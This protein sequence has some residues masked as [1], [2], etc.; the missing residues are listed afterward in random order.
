MAESLTP[1]IVSKHVFNWMQET[2]NSS[3]TSFKDYLK[4]DNMDEAKFELMLI[5]Y[6]TLVRVLKRD[7]ERNFDEYE[8]TLF[9]H[10]LSYA[11]SKGIIAKLSPN[12]F[13]FLNDRLKMINDDLGERYDD[14]NWMMAQSIH[15]IYYE[16]LKSSITVDNCFLNRSDLDSSNPIMFMFSNDLLKRIDTLTSTLG[17]ITAK[18]NMG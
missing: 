5:Y 7:L 2:A 13:D 3:L 12:E 4:H 9:E 18:I 1:E 14:H 11:E 16:P 17:L 8:T 6:L 10:L 15:A